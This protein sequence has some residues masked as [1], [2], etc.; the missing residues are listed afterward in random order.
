MRLIIS[1]L[2]VSPITNSPAS[3][4]S[5]PII[6]LKIVDLP[7]PLGPIIPIPACGNVKFK[8]SYNLSPYALAT[9][10]ASIT[11]VPKRGP[12]GYKFLIFV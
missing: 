8:L 12:L 7:A 5:S 4:F 9:P 10:L 2:L 6:I 3:G 1:D 11:L